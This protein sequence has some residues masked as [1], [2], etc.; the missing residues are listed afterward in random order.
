M[1]GT[2]IQRCRQTREGTCSSPAT[3]LVTTS[4]SAMTSTGMKSPGLFT[5]FRYD[6]A[7]TMSRSKTSR[8]TASVTQAFGMSTIELIRISTGA[9]LM[10]V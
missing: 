3:S 5:P 2:G 1:K 9:T 6:A 4:G 8:G 10:M 7:G